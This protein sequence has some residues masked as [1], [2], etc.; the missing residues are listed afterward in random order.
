MSAHVLV[1]GPV[2]QDVAVHVEELPV[3]DGSWLVL[4]RHPVDVVDPAGG[5]DAFVGVLAALLARGRSVL[6]AAPLCSAAAPLTVAH[7]GARPSF[8]ERRLI[9]LASTH[10]GPGK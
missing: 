7:L 1:A 4:P 9:A 6:I 3:A 2:V 5:R 8:D 10:R